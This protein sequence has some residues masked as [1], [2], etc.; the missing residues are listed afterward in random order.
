MG[1]DVILHERPVAQRD[2]AALDGFCRRTPL[3]VGR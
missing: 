3:P 2:Y 1:L